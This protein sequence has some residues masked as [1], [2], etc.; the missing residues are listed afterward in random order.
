MKLNNRERTVV[1]I[2]DDQIKKFIRDWQKSPYEWNTEIDI[3]AEIYSRLVRQFKLHNVLIGKIKYKVVLDKFNN[4]L[5]SYRRVYC[6]PFVYY[7]KNKHDKKRSCYPDIVIYRDLANPKHPPDSNS[8]KKI[9][10]PILIAIEIKYE[11]E[12]SGDF[13][14]SHKKSDIAKMRYLIKQRQD[15]RILGAEYAWCLNFNRSKV[16][17]ILGDSFKPAKEEISSRMKVYDIKSRN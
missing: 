13:Q 6:E 15:K 11:N 14:P 16:E 1:E 10:F 9:N 17:F 2:A 4:T 8:N 5:Q 12:W 3:Q 7:K